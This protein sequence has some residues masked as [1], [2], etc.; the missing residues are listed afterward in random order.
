MAYFEK[1]SIFAFENDT[2]C[3]CSDFLKKYNYP[4][5]LRTN[6]Y[7]YFLYKLKLSSSKQHHKLQ[8]LWH[9]LTVSFY[10]DPSLHTSALQYM[11]IR[12]QLIQI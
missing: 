9:H 2:H 8:W 7:F 11:A 10:I 12:L 3:K 4:I 1:W 6:N 5:F